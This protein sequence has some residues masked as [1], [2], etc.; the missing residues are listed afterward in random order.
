[1]AETNKLIA[2]Q[3][4]LKKKQEIYSNPRLEK[5]DAKLKPA[6]ER[7]RNPGV[8]KLDAE[9]IAR[10]T[11]VKGFGGGDS[12]LTPK[13]MANQISRMLKGEEKDGGRKR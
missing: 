8:G 5:G 13:D 9:K 7:E 2:N 10:N 3:E 4:K 1:M 12:P 11:V 6:V